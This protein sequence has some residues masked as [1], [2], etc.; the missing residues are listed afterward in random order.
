MPIYP[1][2]TAGTWRVVVWAKLAT[3]AK[4]KPHERIVTGSK[5]QAKE[6]EARWS[7]ELRSQSARGF[8]VVPTLREFLIGQYGPFVHDRIA[9]NTWRH[10]YRWRMAALESLLGDLRVTEI[11]NR[12]VERYQAERCVDGR[13]ASPETVNGEVQL[14]RSILLYAERSHGLRCQPITVRALKT[15][16]SRRDAWSTAQVGRLLGSARKASPWMVPMIL[17]A[18]NT[19][20]RPGE[21]VAAEW[22][23]VD[24][25]R[26]LLWVPSNEFWR[27]KS[28]KPR[29]I[30]IGT[31]AR[32]VL[33]K[34]QP[35]QHERWIFP[36]RDGGR[37]AAWPKAEFR[38]VVLLAG[39]TG[40]GHWLRHTFASHYLANGGTMFDLAQI[41][42]HSSTYTTERYSHF[43]P[44]HAERSRNVVNLGRR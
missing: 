11:G 2:K 13:R 14:L 4:S 33:T 26:W 28:G 6:Y 34:P 10:T 20:L 8:R 17:F 23:W 44:D 32:A 36:S 25:K 31:V 12:D 39:L 30:P 29:E 41:L 7:L 5:R 22:S 37:F 38:R 1:G 16:E 9:E 35:R 27:P 3:A 18:L 24:R 43:L 15:P 42:G 21:V 19:G 40:S